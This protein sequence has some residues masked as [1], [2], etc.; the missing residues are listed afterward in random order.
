MITKRIT[1]IAQTP[2]FPIWISIA[3]FNA[4]CELVRA[5]AFTVESDC[6]HIKVYI[7]KCMKNQ[8][9]DVLL[10]GAS[11]S[12][13]LASLK[14]FES[15]QIKGVITNL[16]TCDTN[17]LEK[18]IELLEDTIEQ[19]NALGLHGEKIFGYLSEGPFTAIQMSCKEI[20]E[21]TPKPGTGTKVEATDEK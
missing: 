21:Q 12:F 17:K 10:E 13:L 9:Q 2:G 8:I 11:I 20:F 14:D 5:T 16:D 4:T 19:T 15:Y 18:Q 3:G 1:E 6:Q 7:P